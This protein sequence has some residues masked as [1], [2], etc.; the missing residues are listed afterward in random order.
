MICGSADCER[1]NAQ[2]SADSKQVRVEITSDVI[3][4]RVNASLRAEYTM[5]EVGGIGM[6]HVPSLA[7]LSLFLSAYPAL[8]RWANEYRRYAAGVPSHRYDSFFICCPPL[9]VLAIT[10]TLVG[11]QAAGSQERT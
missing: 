6:R 1:L 11:L 2:I 5:N 8:T 9:S 3:R 4:D 7:G 10:T